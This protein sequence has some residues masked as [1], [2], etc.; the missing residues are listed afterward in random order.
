M[1]TIHGKEKGLSLALTVL[2]KDEVECLET[3]FKSIQPCREAFD[4]IVVGWTGTNPKTKEILDTYATRIVPIVWEW[5]HGKARQELHDA[6]STDL[7][8]WLDADD[9][10]GIR[11]ETKGQILPLPQGHLQH[12]LE[13]AFADPTVGAVWL[14]YLYGF[15]KDGNLDSLMARE[16]VVRRSWYHWVGLLHENLL[17][18]DRFSRIARDERVSSIEI[19]HNTDRTRVLASQRRCLEIATKAVERERAAGKIDP[20]T[21]LDMG[22]ALMANG[23]FD[24]A[25]ETLEDYTRICGWDDMRY[26]AFNL[27]A[28]MHRDL[29]QYERAKECNHLAM[30]MKPRWPDAFLGLAKTAFREHRWEDVIFWC[31]IVSK[32]DK[33]AGVIPCDPTSWT[34]FPLKLLHYAYGNL[35]DFPKAIYIAEKALQYYP[36][37]QVIQSCLKNYKKGIQHIRLQKALVDVKEWLEDHQEDDKLQHLV[38][39]IPHAMSDE[40]TFVRLKNQLFPNREGNRIAIYC[41]ASI[42][43]WDPRSV[44]TGIGGSEEAVIYLAPLLARL[45]YVVDVY[46][47]VEEEAQYSGVNWKYYHT[48]DRDFN[49]PDIFIAWRLPDYIEYA[50]KRPI[51]CFLWCHDV[52]QENNWDDTRVERVDKVFVLSKYHRTFFPMVPEDKIFYTR[53]GIILKDFAGELPRDPYQCVYMSSPDRGLEILLRG[54]S[55][56]K[57]AVPEATLKVAYGFTVNYDEKN[58]GNYPMIQFKQEIL[59]LCQQDGVEYLGRVSHEKVA[60]LTLSGGIW[61]YPCTFSEISCISAMKAQAGGLVPV[62]SD[63]AALGETVQYGVR[64]KSEGLMEQDYIDA[65]IA[66]L[67]DPKRIDAMREPMREWAHK[68]FSWDGVAE[69]WH[70]LFV[71]AKVPA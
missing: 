35:G 9:E 41:G 39:A 61:C 37:D 19:K 57:A 21:V 26:F 36:S 64:L 25:I 58:R 22:R 48:Y 12:L 56:I 23:I 38:Q 49:P 18:K 55:Q 54:W 15:D 32:C 53:N 1:I 4:E 40:P 28:D 3:M 5:D 47:N 52:I 16:R 50:P 42:E 13:M 6:V 63:Y 44:K 60:N 8:M 7:V 62:V 33:P 2:C 31:E 65:V 29:D 45:G 14:D 17:D 27:M 43:K 34:S 10:M 51:K 66:A 70:E 68:Q 59:D 69:S 20:R 71:G 46:G 30:M 67:K 24:K 11:G